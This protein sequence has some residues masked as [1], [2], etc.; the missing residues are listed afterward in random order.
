M[1]NTVSIGAAIKGSLANVVIAHMEHLQALVAVAVAAEFWYEYV[2][3]ECNWADARSRYADAEKPEVQAGWARLADQNSVEIQT[4]FPSED[5]W[6]HPMML[7][8]NYRQTC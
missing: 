4:V 3:S 8:Q 5:E 2:P 7:F 1:D 6:Q